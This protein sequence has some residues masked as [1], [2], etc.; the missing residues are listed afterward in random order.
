MMYKKL[1]KEFNNSSDLKYKKINNVRVI[2]LESLCSS[3]RINEYIIKNIA[4]K[5]NY[6][7]LRDIISGPSIVYLE[8]IKQASYYLHNGYALIY[9]DKDLLVCEVK[10]DLYRGISMPTVEPGVNGPKDSFNESIQTNLGLIKRRIKTGDLINRDFTLGKTTKSLISLLYIKDLPQSDLIEE[11]SN[12]LEKLQEYDVI[13]IEAI[14]EKMNPGYNPL[15]TILKTERPDVV[16]SALLDGKIAIIGDNSPY[17]LIIP[18]FLVDF[19]NP[20]G[21]KYVKPISANFMKIIRFMCLIITLTLPGLYLAIIN[22]NPE[23]IPLSLLLSFQASRSG[24]PFSSALECIFMIFISTILRESDI[25][26]PSNYGSPISIIGALVLGEAAVAASLVSPIM[27]IVVG[28]TFITGLV[29]SNGEII[30]GFK[31]FR[32]LI[33]IMSCVLGLYGFLVGCFITLIV[34]ASTNSFG[35]PYLFPI[36]PF[37]KS[38]F[39]ESVLKKRKKNNL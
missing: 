9:D 17:V 38:Y 11:V 12:K 31:F 1:K 22:Y 20:Q 10:A 33:L 15:P 2:Y 36:T 4:L 39:F 26:F 32:L 19:V 16:C 30:N 21:D 34:F 27:I 28:I 37:N 25:R 24:V 8:D 23:A 5:K 7:N 14:I 35:K 3:N 6:L 18:A 13:D 29:F